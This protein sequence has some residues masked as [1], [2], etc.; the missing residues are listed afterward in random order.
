MSNEGGASF[1][2]AR[3]AGEFQCHPP[4]SQSNA[5]AICFVWQPRANRYGLQSS[6]HQD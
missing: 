1:R 5:L 4:A 3:A 2:R 6:L